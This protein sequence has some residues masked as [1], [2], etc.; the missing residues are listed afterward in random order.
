MF[1]GLV[2]E[3]GKRY[4]KVVDNP[5]HISAAVLDTSS[6]DDEL[7]RVIVEVDECETLIANL[8]LKH[9][10]LQSQ[11]DLQFES[12]SHVAFYTTGG[13]SPVHLSGYVVF[14]DEEVYGDEEQDGKETSDEDV[15]SL[16]SPSTIIAKTAVTDDTKELKNKTTDEGELKRKTEDKPGHSSKK[17]KML[18]YKEQLTKENFKVNADTSDDDSSD[19]EEEDSDLGENE[20]P[21]FAIPVA[22]RME[23]EAKLDGD[24]KEG[25]SKNIPKTQTL[26]TKVTVLKD[27]KTPNFEKKAPMTEAQT[28]RAGAP[29]PKNKKTPKFEKKSPMTESQSE[30]TPKSDK[31]SPVNETQTSKAVSTFKS[32]MNPKSEKKVPMPEK[33]TP[34]A[35]EKTSKKKSAKQM[36]NLAKNSDKA[37]S[38]QGTP[39]SAKVVKSGG[40][41]CED[42][43]IGTGPEAKHGKM[44]SVYYEGRLLN[45]KMFDK[46]DSGKGLKFRMGYGEVISGWDVGVTGMKVGGKRRIICPPHMAYGKKGTPGIPPQS[47]LV[48]IV[49]L[50]SVH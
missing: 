45:N 37:K 46:C 13:K 21:D 12:G 11:L 44:V 48:F 17:A 34:K 50:K 16:V 8:S 2:I 30:K 26:I 23:D 22:G 35:E 43:I 10:I 31:K 29:T 27:E 49:E 3:P 9:G 38:L 18:D 32:E 24:E 19:S 40:V 41:T 6:L 4:T 28:P 20:L 15:P 47:T 36:E 33:Q 39:P 14:D 42:L 7:V 25:I 1:W 5:F